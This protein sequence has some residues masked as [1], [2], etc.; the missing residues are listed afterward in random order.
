MA[1]M[2]IHKARNDPSGAPPQCVDELAVLVGRAVDGCRTLVERDD[3]RRTR[4][5]TADNVGDDAVPRQ[6]GEQQVKLARELD[7]FVAIAHV[8][9][10]HLRGD[11]PL[12]SL[13]LHAAEAPDERTRQRRLDEAPGGKDGTRLLDARFGNKRAAIGMQRDDVR[14]R[15]MMKRLAH[16]C[17][18]YAEQLGK[19][20]FAEFGARWQPVLF[21][22]ANNLLIDALSGF[23][24]R[25]GGRRALAARCASRASGTASTKGSGSVK[26]GV[27]E[28]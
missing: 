20:F 4:D 24:L 1:Q 6:L 16:A 22:G 18:A 14:Q 15:Q 23:G 26:H 7:A 10:G 19:S 5:Q 8:A 9:G 17:P 28:I 27:R 12:E 3:E 21:D 11:V 2:V 13:E 25:C